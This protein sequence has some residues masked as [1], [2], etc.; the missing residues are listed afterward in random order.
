MRANRVIY[1]NNEIPTDIIYDYEPRPPLAINPPINPH[2]FELALSSCSNRCMWSVFH[3]CVEPESGSYALERIPK[4]KAAFELNTGGHE[5][6]WGIQAQH[7]ISF[8]HMLFY[9]CLIIAG[10]FGFWVWWEVNNPHDLQSAAVPL[11][12][13]AVLLS[14]FWSSAGVLRVLREP[15]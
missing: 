11:T 4:R 10:T 5:E 9:H 15:Q 6:A 1:V 3:D 7:V 8:I 13:V 12:T 14:L 2:E